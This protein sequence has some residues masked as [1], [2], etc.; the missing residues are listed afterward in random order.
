MGLCDSQSLFYHRSLVGSIGGLGRGVGLRYVGYQCAAIDYSLDTLPIRTVVRHV[1]FETLR[2]RL[3]C[4]SILVWRTLSGH[5]DV[6]AQRR[7]QFDIGASGSGAVRLDAG[8]REGGWQ[9]KLSLLDVEL[10]CRRRTAI[11]ECH[12]SGKGLHMA[13][14]F[15][16]RFMYDVKSYQRPLASLVVIHPF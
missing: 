2:L 10:E 7:G 5:H 1:A 4:S 11:G 12:L 3:L 15:F 13:C 9:P 8:I 6:N 16:G 14:D